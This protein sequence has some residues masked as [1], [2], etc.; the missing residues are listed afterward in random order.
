MSRFG[1]IR[2]Y[3][4][5]SCDTIGAELDEWARVHVERRLQ[6]RRLGADEG[7]VVAVRRV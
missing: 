4:L 6:E 2:G 1:G 7:I 3:M 5:M